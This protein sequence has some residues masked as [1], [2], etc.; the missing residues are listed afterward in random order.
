MS[1]SALQL[2]SDV[3]IH[4]QWLP[5]EQYCSRVAPR[6]PDQWLSEDANI[7]VYL[8]MPDNVHIKQMTLSQHA[9]YQCEW[10][11]HGLRET[12]GESDWDGEGAD[13]VSEEAI[14]IA[15]DVVKDFPGE[16]G[17]PEV[18][19]DPHGRVD[20]DWHLDNGA[21][22]TIS[23]AEDGEVAVSGLYEG[24]SKLTGMAWDKEADIPSLV[25]CGLEWLAGMKS[26]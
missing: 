23:I 9:Q 26:R 24:Q 12:A 18:S 7:C 5:V 19:A 17:R 10:D 11:I 8:L 13:P 22:F 6:L 4:E 3:K 14:R 2:A 25:H 1:I 15:L 16:V 20:F 21:M